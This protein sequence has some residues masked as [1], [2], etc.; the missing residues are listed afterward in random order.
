LPEREYI[1][2]PMAEAPRTF[3]HRSPDN[4]RIH[5]LLEDVVALLRGLGARVE[6]DSETFR[7]ALAA[8]V[9]ETAPAQPDP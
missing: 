8:T 6:F 4:E 5:V 2:V 3:D 1:K 7:A 9:A